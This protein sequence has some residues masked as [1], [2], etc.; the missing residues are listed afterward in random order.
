MTPAKAT[1]AITE[2]GIDTLII[3]GLPARSLQKK[4]RTVQSRITQG[5][6]GPFAIVVHHYAKTDDTADV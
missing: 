1:A 6:G 5:D 2:S 4:L 3:S